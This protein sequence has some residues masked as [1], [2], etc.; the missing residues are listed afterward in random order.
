M[1][2]GVLTCSGSTTSDMYPPG[3]V[4]LVARAPALANKNC[5]NRTRFCARPGLAHRGRCKMHLPLRKP[6][7]QDCEICL[8][9]AAAARGVVVK[10]DGSDS[11][12]ELASGRTFNGRSASADA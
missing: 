9:P 3:V 12:V 11:A 5:L 7:G 4:R 8:R 6:P 2:R 1:W 10:F